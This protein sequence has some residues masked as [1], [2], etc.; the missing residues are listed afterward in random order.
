MTQ[1]QPAPSFGAR[2]ALAA[3]A[4]YRAIVSP[5]LVALFGYAC[6]YEPS[7]SEY[8]RLAIAEHGLARGASLALRRLARCHPLGGHGFDPPPRRASAPIG[9]H[10]GRF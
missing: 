10:D 3:L 1:S 5:L 7:C 2:I 8:A 9:D 4:V 6:R